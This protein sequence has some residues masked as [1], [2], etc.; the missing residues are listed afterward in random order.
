[1][2]LNELTGR[3]FFFF[4]FDNENM[5]EFCR[6][7]DKRSKL[8]AD[9]EALFRLEEYRELFPEERRRDSPA[10]RVPGH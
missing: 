1:M 4:F 8:S 9:L 2:K 10:K 6:Y 3:N 5:E 7:D